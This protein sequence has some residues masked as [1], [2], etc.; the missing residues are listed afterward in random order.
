[1]KSSTLCEIGIY[2]YKN[3]HHFL[4]CHFCNYLFISITHQLLKFCFEKFHIDLQNQDLAS[5]YMLVL[6]FHFDFD[7]FLKKKKKHQP[8]ILK[9]RETFF[10]N[11]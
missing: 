2:F 9:Q 1:M 8:H 4:A 10:L 11:V 6:C 3:M 5:T 7:F